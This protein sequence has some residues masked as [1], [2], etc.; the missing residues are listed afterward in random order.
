MRD[1]FNLE[2]IPSTVSQRRRGGIWSRIARRNWPFKLPEF[3]NDA[4]FASDLELFGPLL[5]QNAFLHTMD[6]PLARVNVMA[7]GEGQAL[8][9][10]FDRSEFTTTLQLEQP[11]AGW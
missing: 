7:Y 2:Q 6:R 1:L 11:D 10:H 3:M 8:N 4:E 9:W 5:A